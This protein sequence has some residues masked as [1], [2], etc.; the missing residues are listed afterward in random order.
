MRLLVGEG[1]Q[2]LGNVDA[3]EVNAGR[4]PSLPIPLVALLGVALVA[5]GAGLFWDLRTRPRRQKFF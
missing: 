1:D 4:P 3:F 5:A 2:P